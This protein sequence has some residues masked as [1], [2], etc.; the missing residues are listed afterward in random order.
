MTL[1]DDIIIEKKRYVEYLKSSDYLTTLQGHVFNSLSFKEAIQSDDLS[2]IAEVKKASPSKG[3]INSNFDHLRLAKYY[4]D[5]GASALSVLTDKL[6]FQGDNAYLMD[7]KQQVSLPVLRKDFMIDPIQIKESSLIGADA[8]LLI[9]AVLSQNQAQEL[10]DCSKENDLDILLEI[11][12][13]HDLEKALCLKGVDIM[14]INNRNLNSFD[15]DLATSLVLKKD[16]DVRCDRV[17]CVA[18]SG[19]ESVD[20]LEI[21]EDHGFSAVLI[22]EGLV[23]NPNM[24][25]YF[26]I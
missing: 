24:I 22:G 16:V 21:L 6:F 5:L 18:E 13:I 15:V 26:N 12:T 17:Y 1:L 4:C 9:V 14:G 7:I 23:K 2:L 11:H 8:I 20:E 10:I 25:D 3:L 19:Y